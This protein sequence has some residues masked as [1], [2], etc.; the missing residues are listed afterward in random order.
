[1]RISSRLVSRLAFTLGALEGFLL[2]AFECFRKVRG[3]DHGAEALDSKSRA[4]PLDIEAA[5]SKL[6]ALG[7]IGIFK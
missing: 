2:A 4:R 3:S 1:M 7:G 6:V 5:K